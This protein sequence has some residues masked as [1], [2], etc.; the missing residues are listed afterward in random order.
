MHELPE[1]IKTRIR[2]KLNYLSSVKKTITYKEMVDQCDIPQPYSIRKLINFL[3]ELMIEEINLGLP[4]RSSLVVSKSNSINQIK[5]PTKEFFEIAKEYGIYDG[6]IE[7][8]ES[9]EFY[10]KILNKVLQ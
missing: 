1:N 6:E 8:M 10:K 2:S 4:I 3:A 7:G 5:I 9:L